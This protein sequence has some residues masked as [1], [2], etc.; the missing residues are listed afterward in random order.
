MNKGGLAIAKASSRAR[1]HSSAKKTRRPANRADL[2][3]I[4]RRETSAKH[5]AGWRVVVVRRGKSMHK[6][7]ADHKHGGKTRALEAAKV[8]RDQVAKSAS[9]VDYVLWRR[10]KRSRPSSSGIVGVGRYEVQYEASRHPVWEAAWQDADGKRH[11]RRFF[12]SVHGERGAKALACAARQE[13]TA[14]LR[15]EL[16]RRGRKR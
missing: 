13:G 12:I 6:H 3:N 2:R 5:P 11:S 8:W 16:L 15:R 10:Q 4:F 9:D 1:K 7:F 14:Q